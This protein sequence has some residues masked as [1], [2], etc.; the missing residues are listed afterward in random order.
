M[1]IGMPEMDGITAAREIPKRWPDNGPKVVAITAFAVEGDRERCLEAGMDSY[2]AKPVKMNE[3]A[4]I[5]AKCS[6]S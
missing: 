1:D 5:L 4:E 2:L 6:T 3:L